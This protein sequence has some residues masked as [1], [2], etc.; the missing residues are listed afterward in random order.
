ME[1]NK[2]TWKDH[3]L[4]SG[5][6]LEFEIKRF[7]D[8]KGCIS[9]MERTYL[10]NNE[11]EV[12]TEFSYDIDSS[13]I[14]GDHFIDLM[15]E[16]K[17]RHENV[18]WVFLP[19]T[20]GSI[21]DINYTDFMHALDHFNTHEYHH[22]DFPIAFGPLCSKGVELTSEGANPKTITQAIAQLSYAMADKVTNAVL[23]QTDAVLST[24]FK[25]TTFYSIPIIVTTAPLY[26]L[27][28]DV[29]I[30]TIKVSEKLEDVATSEPF[31]IL[32]AQPGSDLLKHNRE[33]FSTFMIERGLEELTAK[34]KSFN[35]D[36]R[37]V[38][39]N[40]ARGDCPNSIVIIQHTPDNSGLIK[41]FEYINRVI[42]PDQ[43]IFDL[44]KQRRDENKA[45][46]EKFERDYPGVDLSGGLTENEP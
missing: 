28:D 23:H 16:C 7:L 42:K 46:F 15:I 22:V 31:L 5:L 3:L 27:R 26:R 10:R 33:I 37:F 44:I 24:H 40:I 32:K 34:L 43:E 2:S 19:E 39:D 6:P 12:P 38:F 20:Y 17:Y 9:N 18:R 35:S 25:S 4:K 45:F 8:D 36:P 13:Y 1:K 29:D 21:D 11:A 41:F 14:K 30:Q